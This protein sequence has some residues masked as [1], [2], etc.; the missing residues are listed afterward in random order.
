MNHLFEKLFE[1]F[2]LQKMCSHKVQ[3]MLQAWIF[4]K[5]FLHKLISLLSSGHS[6]HLITNTGKVCSGIFHI[7]VVVVCHPHESGKQELFKHFFN[8][9]SE[10]IFSPVVFYVCFWVTYC[11]QINGPWRQRRISPWNVG[12]WLPELVASHPKIQYSLL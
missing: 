2:I 3:C 11:L 4:L 7:T 9:F 1:I 6:W 12:N 10:I 5:H 8:K